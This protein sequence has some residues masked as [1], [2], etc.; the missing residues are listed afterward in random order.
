MTWRQGRASHAYLSTAPFQQ[1]HVAPDSAQLS[2]TFATADVSEAAAA[3][4]S[5]A[6][7]VLREDAGLQRPPTI[8]F[9]SRDE[10]AQQ[11]TAHARSTRIRRN[12]DTDFDN[13]CIDGAS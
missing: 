12:V 3:M 13:A 11:S 10:G 5:E 1:Q 4:K 2:Q 9:R 6:C 8:L 7:F